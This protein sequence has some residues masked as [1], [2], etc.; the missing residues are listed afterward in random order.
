M[1]RIA[2][3]L[4]AFLKAGRLPSRR[5]V[6][7]LAKLHGRRLERTWPYLKG[8]QN[9]H[10]NLAFED[11]LEFQ[12]ARTRNFQVMVIGA[13]DGVENDPIGNFI[14]R[15]ECSGI[16]VEP[17]PAVFA[18]LQENL[19]ERPAFQFINAAVDASS[20]TREFFHVRSGHPAFPAWTE[21]LA[22]FDKSH[23]EKHEQL[24]PGLSGHIES[25]MVPTVSFADLLDQVRVRAIDVLQIDAEGC[26]AL[27]LTWFPFDRLKPAVI[28]FEIAHMSPADLQATRTRLSGHG[29]RLFATESSSDEMAVLL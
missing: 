9:T 3:N 29:Y 26:D 4:W 25:F 5:A 27:L 24:V 18:R 20:G 14:L 2:A 13:Y 22:S 8:A 19:R 12:Y 15:H 7:A 21:Q 10:L 17:Q 11:V 28:H 16:F 23:I 1:A 6:A